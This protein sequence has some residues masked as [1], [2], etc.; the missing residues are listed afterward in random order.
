MNS[1]ITARTVHTDRIDMHVYESGDVSGTPIVFLHGNLSDATF[2]HSTLPAFAG[3]RCI[4]PDLRCFGKTAPLPIDATRGMGDFADDLDALLNALDT[5]PVVLVA[6]SAGGGVAMRYAMDHTDRVRGVVLVD[7]LSP[8]GF[9]GT[10]DAQ[11]TPTWP[12]YAGSGGGTAAADMVARLKAGDRSEDAPTA[13]RTVLRQCYVKPPFVPA[14]EE[15]LLDAM[16][17]TTLG[18]DA[19]PGDGT[20]SEN[21]PGVAPGTRGMNN[22]ISPKYLTLDRFGAIQNGPPVLWIRGADDVI[23]SDTSLFDFGFLGQLGAVPDWPGADVFPPQPMVAQ[24]RAVLATY[25]AN[26]G[27]VTEQVIPDCGHSPQVEKP[28]VFQDALTAFL[29]GLN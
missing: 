3:A 2:W 17:R 27:R 9:G 19:Y 21:W 26:G 24:T 15:A 11:G 22:A 29:A 4:A 28:G 16:F 10:K 14:D 8:Y 13:P 6:H 7:P 25:E 5:G 12:D 18:D 23:V 1:S 20:A